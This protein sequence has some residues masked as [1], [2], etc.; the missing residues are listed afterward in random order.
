MAKTYEW[1][2]TTSY[3]GDAP[4]LSHGA[5]PSTWESW[6]TA[7]AGAQAPGSI[8]Y[9]YRDA[10]ISGPGGFTDA[11]SSR[12]A[13][14]VTDSWTASIDNNNNLT[15]VLTTTLNSIVRDDLRGSNQDTPGRNI[16]VYREQGAAPIFSYTD[17]QLASAHTILG[18]PIV[19]AQETLVLP[20]GQ[21]AERSS[22]YVH[23]QTVGASSYDDIWAGIQFKNPLPA[24]Y[25]P[26]ERKISGVW[27]S[28]NR[29]GGVCSR[30]VNGT[31]VELR[32][33]DGGVGTGNPPSIKT[34]GTWYNQ[35]KVGQE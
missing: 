9:W 35:K 25:R 31:W 8:T 19:L 1:R 4:S 18:S 3:R 26:G 15:I 28:H 33:L 5:T 16:N 32:T 13:I 23:N 22:L 27:S 30:K 7:E 20:P 34:S 14:S 12:V 6:Q 29:N 11:N 21:G 10:N 17:T 2:A 24:D